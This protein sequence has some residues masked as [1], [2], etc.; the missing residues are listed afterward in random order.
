M[1]LSLFVPHKQAE[2]G[3][4]QKNGQILGTHVG[5]KDLSVER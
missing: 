5:T 2:S 4:K 1:F 3:R